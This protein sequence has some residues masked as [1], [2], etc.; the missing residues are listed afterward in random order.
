MSE[1]IDVAALDAKAQEYLDDY[2][3]TIEEML[4]DLSTDPDFDGGCPALDGCWVEWDGHCP[5]GFPSWMIY[6][7]LV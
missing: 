1:I 3:Q 2:G 4:E 7:G 6:A 5:H